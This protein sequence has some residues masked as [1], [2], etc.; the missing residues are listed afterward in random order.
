MMK[1]MLPIFALSCLPETAA[2]ETNRPKPVLVE[3]QRIWDQAPHNGFTDLIRFKDRWY[4]T[5]RE[6]ESH[7]SHDGVLKVIASDDGKEWESVATFT[8]LRGFDMRE[9]KFSVTPDGRLMLMGAEGIRNTEPAQHQSIVWFSSDGYNWS[10]QFAVADPDFWLWRGQWHKGKAYFFGY[11]CRDDNHSIRLYTST[12]GKN[13]D[14]LIDKVEVEGTY[15]NETSMLFL[16]D[17]TCYCLLRQDGEPKSGYIGKSFPPYTDWEWKS[18]GIRIGGPGM[19]QLPD[20]RFVAVVRRYADSHEATRTLL[21]W[22]D[23]EE[24]TLEEALEL[25]SGGDTSYAGLVWHDDLLWISYYSTHEVKTNV[26]LAKVRFENEEK[27]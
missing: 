2:S 8:S 4:C 18:L 27:K 3:V 15:P 16:P 20:G 22:L 25:P 1:L 23:P 13:Y 12:D 26:Y 10:E 24:G 6:G 17:D 14:T 11:G 9:A 7:V 19:I 21:Y 5:F